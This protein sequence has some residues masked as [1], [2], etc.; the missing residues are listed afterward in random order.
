MSEMSGVL[1]YKMEVNCVSMAAKS[2]NKNNVQPAVFSVKIPPENLESLKKF[3][4]SMEISS[5]WRPKMKS[6]LCYCGFQCLRI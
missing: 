1:C 3:S 5:A 6:F 4:C 2:V